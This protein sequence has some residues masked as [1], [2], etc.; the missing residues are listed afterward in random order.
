[1]RLIDQISLATTAI[2]RYPLR[3]SMLLVATA[4]GVSA[5]LVL[6]SLGEGGR[7]YITGQFQSLG[8]NLLVVLPGKNEVSGG[9]LPG[10]MGGS[11]RD[12]TLDDAIAISQSRNV[13]RIAPIIPGAGAIE[14]QGLVRDVDIV[15]TSADMAVIQRF[16]LAAG[17]FLPAT[18]L[19]RAS[20]VCVVGHS[21]V[22][23]VFRNTNPIGQWL[24]VGERRFRVIGFMR[25]SGMFG[26]V[27]VDEALFIPVASAQQLFNTEGI[28]R[29]LVEATS[30]EA[31]PLAEQD[32]INTIIARHYGNDDVTVVAPDAI[33]STFNTIFGAVSA[34]LAGIAAISLVVAG[35]LIM[36]VMLVAVS[37]RTE[38]IGLFKALGAKRHQV[39]ALFI[40]EA[41]VLSL[42]GALVG[43]LAGQGAVAAL[44]RLYPVVDF[45]APLWAVGAAL[46]TA[47]ASGLVFGI[48]PARRAADLDPV[49][50]LSGH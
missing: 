36:N 35:T 15:G 26:G 21:L 41:A 1:M 2:L 20:P 25:Q 31:M 46:L 38:E 42:M 50:A 6:T 27:D 40:T 3:T 12:L 48:L 23:E 49:A 34:A 45:Q 11:T 18:D 16:E 22:E 37:Q 4:I 39:M 7:R 9:G 8:A 17:K 13:A 43:L 44:R 24:R 19:D 29:L 14:Y 47:L 30:A 33:V 32:I 5:V 28:F 10:M